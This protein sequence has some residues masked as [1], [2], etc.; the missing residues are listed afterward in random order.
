MAKERPWDRQ[1]GETDKAFLA[2]TF[3]R[4]IPRAQR[5]VRESWRRYWEAK[6]GSCGFDARAPGHWDAWSRK[7]KWIE[8]ANLYDDH[9]RA[10]EDKKRIEAIGEDAKVWAQ[11]R[12]DQRQVEWELAELLADRARKMLAFPLQQQTTLKDG[13]TVV[14]NPV[15]WAARDIA[16]FASLLGKL[17][18]QAV[19]D[20]A[21]PDAEATEGRVN[22][23]IKVATKDK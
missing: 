6:T 10:V 8:R 17:G 18:R 22:V 20:Q 23:T 12:L 16:T 11:R 13:K 14:I 5:S 1:K 15:R 7:W 19:D 4:N 2:F 3:F 21:R 9:L